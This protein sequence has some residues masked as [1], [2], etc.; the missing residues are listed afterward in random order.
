[1]RVLVSTLLALAACGGR[2]GFQRP[3]YAADAE[4][5]C[6]EAEAASDPRRALALYGMALE[7]NPKM[8]RA[9]YG[10]ALI[11]ENTGRGGEAD[12]SFSMAVEYAAGDVKSRYLL[13]RARRFLRMSRMELAVRDLDDAVARLAAWPLPDV[14]AE[15][16]LLRAECRIKLMRYDGARE[17]LDAAERAGL[18]RAQRGRAHD[19][20]VRVDASRPEERR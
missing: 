12:R 11:L 19:L 7:A 8:A 5:R 4:A 15:V 14:E 13:G 1:V 16:H 17:D 3:D 9:Y 18:D 6:A 20:R 2:A 10:R